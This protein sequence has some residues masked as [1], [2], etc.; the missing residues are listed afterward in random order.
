MA[1]S[2]VA[3]LVTAVAQLAVAAEEA[4]SAEALSQAPQVAE[5]LRVAEMLQM[6][7]ALRAAGMLQRR[8]PTRSMPDTHP[9][10]PPSARW[11]LPSVRPIPA[12]AAAEAMRSRGCASRYPCTV[13]RRVP[14]GWRRRPRRERRRRIPRAAARAWCGRRRGRRVPR[15]ECSQ[16][17][18]PVR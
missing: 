16:W 14:G 10:S 17:P 9:C 15:R 8:R 18:C 2:A 1:L 3:Q 6:A 11:S 5:T 12:P 4:F 7:E 13:L